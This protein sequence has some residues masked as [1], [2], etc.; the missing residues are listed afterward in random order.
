M[1]P[2]H[3]K[4]INEFRFYAQCILIANFVISLSVIFPS[5]LC[6]IWRFLQIW[7]VTD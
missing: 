4:M 3:C 5:W 6:F 7:R 2:K 1:K